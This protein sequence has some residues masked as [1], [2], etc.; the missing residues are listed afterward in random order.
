MT[1]SREAVFDSRVQW[2]PLPDFKALRGSKAT[3][4]E[5]DKA[6]RAEGEW[7]EAVA[8]DGKLYYW[9]T[10]TRQTTWD[11]PAALLAKEQQL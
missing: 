7:R 8:V 4:S 2:G 10:L 11:K 9:N 3:G 1:L 5:K 6:P